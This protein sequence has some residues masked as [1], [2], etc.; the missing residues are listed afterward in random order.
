VEAKAL[1]RQGHF[2]EAAQ[3]YKQLL[4]VQPKSAEAYA[5][6]TRV[7]LKQK[8][9]QLANDT[10]SLGL[11]VVDSAPMHVALG[12]V[13]FREGKLPEA[14]SEWLNAVNSDHANARAYLGLARLST[15]TTQY[16]QAKTE[17]DK[18]HA[19]DPSD[20]D[21]E[22]HWVK[23]LKPSEQLPYLEN[24]F[25]HE[26]NASAVEQVDLQSYVEFLKAR[27]KSPAHNCRL[28]TELTSAEADP[29]AITLE[30]T[31]EIRGYG[32][33]VALNGKNFNLQVDTGAS[34]IL[35]DRIV[36]HKSGLTRLSN[37]MIGGLGD[38]RESNG[39]FAMA[40]PFRSSIPR[41]EH[42]AQHSSLS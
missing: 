12:E 21:I 6:L 41:R 42:P 38:R 20:P 37:V 1:Y 17:I 15:A 35:I 24:Y 22:L 9:V 16:K 32:L 25:S 19:L 29:L 39:Y 26:N 31:T 30:R 5:G 33:A 7:Y 34:G 40:V 18:A 14:E 8:K 10:S 27:L 23:S 11:R 2:D 36:A 28:A 4:Q 3:K 13:F